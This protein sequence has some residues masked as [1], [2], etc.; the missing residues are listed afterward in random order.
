MRKANA[1]NHLKV[2]N[3]PGELHQSTGKL[4]LTVAS[5]EKSDKNKYD[6][7]EK[8]T[9]SQALINQ[10]KVPFINKCKAEKGRETKK[11][12]ANVQMSQTA[13]VV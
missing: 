2:D 8:R 11:R 3:Y 7:R 4:Q 13:G 9:N 5:K 10:H 1:R 12:T 6:I